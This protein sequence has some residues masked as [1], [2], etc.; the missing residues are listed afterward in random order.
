MPQGAE[1]SLSLNSFFISGLSSKFRGRPYKD[2][3][4]F[5]V[6]TTDDDLKLKEMIRNPGEDSLY[7]VMP[8]EGQKD[9]IMSILRKR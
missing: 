4:P 6:R 2:F 5:Y 3:Q 9:S 8:Y 7:M 1:R